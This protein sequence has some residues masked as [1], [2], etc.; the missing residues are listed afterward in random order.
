MH[1]LRDIGNAI[2]TVLI[3]MKVT[4]SHLFVPAIT[5]QYPDVKWTMPERFRGRLYNNIEDCIGCQACARV[6]PVSC[7]YIA[8]EKRGPGEEPQFTSEESGKRPKKLRVTQ[9]DVDL[10]LCCYCGFCTE[11]C[12]TECLRMIPEYEFSVYDKRELLY[13]FATEKSLTKEPEASS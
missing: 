7:I 8:T 13:S 11:Q 3:G 1:Y 12:P 4:V 10:S 2:W 9:Y 5:L 6:C